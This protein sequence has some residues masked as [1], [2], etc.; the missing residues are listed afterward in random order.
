[1]LNDEIGAAIAAVEHAAPPSRASLF[2]DVYA[3][4]P[5]HLKDQQAELLAN[6]EA[7]KIHG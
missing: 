4:L 6:I 2:E 7:P 3:E 5:W 1:V